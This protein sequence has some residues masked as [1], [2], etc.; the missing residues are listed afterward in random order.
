MP[1]ERMIE[2]MTTFGDVGGVPATYMH[3]GHGYE[4]RDDFNWGWIFALVIIFLALVF[5]W[6]RRDGHHVGAG[7]EVLPYMAMLEA[8]RN[9]NGGNCYE[10]WDGHRDNLKEFG[11]LRQEVTANAW[12]QSREIDRNFWQLS[13]EIDN[14]KYQASL[15]TRTI[16]EGYE[17]RFSELQ[18]NLLSEKICDLR[19]RLAEERLVNR[20]HGC[21]YTRASDPYAYSA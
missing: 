18:Q 6:G 1:E 9:K 3:S 15:D 4:R 19:E 17:R 8:G 14:N 5:L 10:H 21:T 13:R 11:Q 7:A 12:T 16:I 2:T 20:L